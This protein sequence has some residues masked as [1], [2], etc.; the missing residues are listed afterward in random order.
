MLDQPPQPD[1]DAFIAR[2][3]ATGGAERSNSQ[4]FLLELC[5]LIGAPRPAGQSGSLGD[6]RF[7]R[8]VS[9]LDP[10]GRPSTRF[11]DFYKRGC[12]I[13]EAKQG[14]YSAPPLP[15]LTG[16]GEADRRARPSATLA[17]GPS[18]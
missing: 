5:D 9:H 10:E 14:G 3:S 1:V 13:L 18:I 4:A 17:A 6:Y 12:F 11:I 15:L 2:W 8:S 7:E 16:V